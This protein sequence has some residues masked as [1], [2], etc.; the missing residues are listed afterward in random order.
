MILIA[1]LSCYAMKVKIKLKYIE[2]KSPLNLIL[3]V[4]FNKLP[5]CILVID[6][7]KT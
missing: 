2:I 6:I 5:K 7:Q 1:V 3:K 4:F